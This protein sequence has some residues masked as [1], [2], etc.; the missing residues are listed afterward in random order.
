MPFASKPLFAIYVVWHPG[1]SAG[2]AIAANIYAHFRRDLFANASGGAGIS[3]LFRSDSG[4]GR[5]TP[6]P[7]DFS[8]AT[9][10]AV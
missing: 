2:S 4:P 9:V 6:P 7:I 1:F 5:N 10:T 8:A 3:V